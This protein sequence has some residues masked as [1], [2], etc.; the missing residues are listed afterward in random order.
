MINDKIEPLLKKF[1]TGNYYAI[2]TT[3]SQYKDRHQI[4]AMIDTY[5]DGWIKLKKYSQ[6]ISG[7]FQENLE[8]SDIVK[9]EEL[10]IEKWNL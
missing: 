2:I 4:I 9:L 1:K 10:P 3:R 6:T 5:S 8:Y 7:R